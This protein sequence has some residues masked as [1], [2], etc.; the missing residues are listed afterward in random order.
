MNIVIVGHGGHSKVIKDI[1]LSQDGNVL[2]GYLDDKFTRTFIKEDVFYGPLTAIKQVQEHYGAVKF[3]IGI[4]NNEVRKKIGM[5]LN[6]HCEDYITVIH[7][8]AII[9]PSALIG[10]GTVV[11]ANSVIQADACVGR[12]SIINTN[13][14][15]EH[16]NQIGDFV[17]VSPSA[18]LTGGVILQDGVHV[19]AGATVIPRKRIGSWSVVGAGSVVIHDIPPSSTAIGVPAKVKQKIEGV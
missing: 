14:V 17:H 11:M 12:H 4:G 18:T 1:I 13:A 3:V 15:I 9:S 16:D 8:S 10:N 5:K 6:L 7:Q 19:G 2:A